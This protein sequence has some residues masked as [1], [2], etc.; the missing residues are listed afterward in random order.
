M[1]RLLTERDV[2]FE[3]RIEPEDLEIEGNASAVCDSGH[4]TPRPEACEGCRQDLET[5]AWIRSEIESG[6]DAAWCRVI[7]TAK[8]A[9][10]EGWDALGGC[11]YRSEDE[12]KEQL[13]PEMRGEAVRHLRETIRVTKERIRGISKRFLGVE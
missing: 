8:L 1:A 5:Y 11:S 10:F 13:L 9:G 4:Q 12:I 6:N 2:E 7:V 3:I